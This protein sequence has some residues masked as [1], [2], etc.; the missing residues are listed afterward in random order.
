[1][2][3]NFVK[4]LIYSSFLILLFQGCRE[5]VS[6]LEEEVISQEILEKLKNSCGTSEFSWLREIIIKAEE[7]YKS[8]KYQG[9]FIGTIYLEDQQNEPVIFV[10]MAMESGGIYG[11]LYHCN[12]IRVDLDPSQ[13]ETFFPNLKKDQII[14]SNVPEN[15]RD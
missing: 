3:Y 4:I 15:I 12:G 11:Y 14:Y 5:D 6:P 10:N 1:M 9:N 8:R 7:D 2:K 13:V